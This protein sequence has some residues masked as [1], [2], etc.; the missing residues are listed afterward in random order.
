MGQV[1]LSLRRKTSYGRI[2][3]YPLCQ[4]SEYILSLAKNGTHKRMAF[5]EKEIA[6]MMDLGW[7]LDI[8]T[9]KEG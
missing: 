3:Y 8:Q 5:T 9:E 1:N 7:E 4:D 6:G 2:N